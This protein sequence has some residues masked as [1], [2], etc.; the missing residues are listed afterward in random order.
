M[1]TLD[2]NFIPPAFNS[3]F[4]YYLSLFPDNTFR[5]SVSSLVPSILKYPT[6]FPSKRRRLYVSISSAHA[7]GASR[8]AADRHVRDF[9]FFFVTLPVLFTFDKKIS[10]PICCSGQPDFKYF[11]SSIYWKYYDIITFFIYYPFKIYCCLHR[12]R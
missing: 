5:S 10:F 6:S 11:H 1:D 12:K 8:S 4:T 3:F 2:K 9:A 7:D